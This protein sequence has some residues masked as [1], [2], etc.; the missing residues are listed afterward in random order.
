MPDYM[1]V[2]LSELRHHWGGAYLISGIIGHWR[3]ERRDDGQALTA[4]DP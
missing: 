4:D 1:S 3:A 2:T